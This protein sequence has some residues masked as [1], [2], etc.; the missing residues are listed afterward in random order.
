M[1]EQ[2]RLW[3]EQ[4]R[5]ALSIR[6][7]GRHRLLMSADG[8]AS[9]SGECHL[10]FT[11][12]TCLTACCAQPAAP[13]TQTF[14]LQRRATINM[15]VDVEL[16]RDHTASSEMSNAE[17]AVIVAV[18]VLAGSVAATAGAQQHR[19]ISSCSF[20][21]FVH[22]CALYLCGRIRALFTCQ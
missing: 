13:S 4:L 11:F 2:P 12:V 21:I 15:S 17:W 7:H 3:R 1:S 18:P 10:I 14:C 5:A 8:A 9:T 6:G 20:L 16:A 22:R 19:V